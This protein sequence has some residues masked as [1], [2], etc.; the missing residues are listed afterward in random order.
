MGI[1]TIYYS[2]KILNVKLLGDHSPSQY[3]YLL[4]RTLNRI[5]TKN[6]CILFFLRFNGLLIM[7]QFS[8]LVELIEDSMCGIWGK[9]SWKKVPKCGFRTHTCILANGAVFHSVCQVWLFSGLLEIVT[10]SCC[11]WLW[12]WRLI[13]PNLNSLWNYY[14]SVAKLERSSRQKMQRMVPQ[15]FWFVLIHFFSIFRG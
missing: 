14:F 15:S 3:K 1:K 7:R 5:K 12:I 10:F 8:P 11:V 2:N 9:N 6:C 13:T 4:V